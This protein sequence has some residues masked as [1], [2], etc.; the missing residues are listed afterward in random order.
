M[1]Y[2]IKYGF[3]IYSPKRWPTLFYEIDLVSFEMST[4][5][6]LLYENF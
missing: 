4:N 5:I 6:E 2:V 1:G 3:F